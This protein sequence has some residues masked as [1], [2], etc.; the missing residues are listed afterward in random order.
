[1]GRLREVVAT[2]L[3]A[4][5]RLWAP[6]QTA[7]SWMQRAA[8]VLANEEKADAASVEASYRALLEDIVTAKSDESVA[9]WATTF[10]KVTRSYWRGLFHCYDVLEIPRTNNELEQYFGAA[11]HHERRATGHKRATS[12]LVVRGS[13]RVVAAV[14]TLLGAWTAQELRPANVKA[15]RCLREKLEARHETRRAARR[16]RRDPVAYLAKLEDGLLHTSL[17]L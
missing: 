9:E 16:F 7:Q 11:R 3:F 10:Y 2:G 15:W 6:L 5:E 4:T 8:E 12:A 17:P 14:A 1:M 13:V